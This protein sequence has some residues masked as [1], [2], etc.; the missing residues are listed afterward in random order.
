MTE[1]STDNSN[2]IVSIPRYN[3]RVHPRF[4]QA[5]DFLVAD[6]SLNNKK[7]YTLSEVCWTPLQNPPLIDWLSDIGTNVVLCGGIHPK[8]QHVLYSL[9]VLVIWGFR[10]ETVPIL[11]DWVTTTSLN[12]LCEHKKLFVSPKSICRNRLGNKQGRKI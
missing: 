11:K 12:D 7:I 3:D 9:G 10:G 1:Q 4:G 5:K 2:L 8:F 6:I